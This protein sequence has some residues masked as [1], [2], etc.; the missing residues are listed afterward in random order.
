MSS[1]ASELGKRL[2][3]LK[4]SAPVPGTQTVFVDED[5]EEAERLADAQRRQDIQGQI[6]SAAPYAFWSESDQRRYEDD[7]SELPPMRELPSGEL[8]AYDPPVAGEL[9]P[10]YG[11][12]Y[13]PATGRMSTIIPGGRPDPQAPSEQ[14]IPGIGRV[15]EAGSTA[16]WGSDQDLRQRLQF[17]WGRINFSQ[18]ELILPTFL[19]EMSRWLKERKEAPTPG[20]MR[21]YEAGERGIYSQTLPE[22][23]PPAAMTPEQLATRQSEGYEYTPEGGSMAENLGRMAAAPGAEAPA[24]GPRRGTLVAP[25]PPEPEPWYK[26]GLDFIFGADEPREPGAPPTEPE[27]SDKELAKK[28]P[29]Q[30]L[31][32]KGEQL[33]ATTEP[34]PAAQGAVTPSER[35]LELGGEAID[36]E[37]LTRLLSNVQ[38][39]QL[40]ILENLDE[41]TLKRVFEELLQ[42]APEELRRA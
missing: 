18:P 21:D 15:F 24:V 13:N 4:M 38:P 39:E 5:L 29:A 35:G 11:Y 19:N 12:A 33:K 2:G 26:P 30:F 7:P 9:R 28:D 41:E 10:G 34:V 32:R 40:S 25:P 42:S 36:P 27:M 23:T 16:P 37:F 17:N 31:K 6:Q 22:Y 3:I 1:Y 20:Q 8:E 14:F